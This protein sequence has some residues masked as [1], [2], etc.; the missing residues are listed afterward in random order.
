MLT[1][2][3]ISGASQGE[4]HQLGS[5]L[6]WDME[7]IILLPLFIPTIS[8][9][10]LVNATCLAIDEHLKVG[11]PGTPCRVDP[12]LG[13]NLLPLTTPPWPLHPQLQQ[14]GGCQAATELRGRA[15]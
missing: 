1:A 2:S 6:W 5:R 9:E 10:L 12:G 13:G 8:I 14:G 4:C 11:D 7:A 15:S 3:S